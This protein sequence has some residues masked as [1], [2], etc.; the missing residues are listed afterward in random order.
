MIDQGK[1]QRN[2]WNAHRERHRRPYS[3]APP[4]LPIV[5]EGVQRLKYVRAWNTAIAIMDRSELKLRDLIERELV[6]VAG[7]NG[8]RVGEAT[9]AV[10]KLMTKIERLRTAAIKKAFRHVRDAH[11]I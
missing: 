7:V 5:P 2:A 1:V 6:N 3:I 10:N 4:P 11:G 9:R 8:I